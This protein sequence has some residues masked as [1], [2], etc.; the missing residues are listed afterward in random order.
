MKKKLALTGYIIGVTLLCLYVL[1]PKEAVTTYLNYR[2]SALS[3]DFQWTLSG[4]KPA[5]PPGIFMDSLSV[6][7]K[8]T[9]LIQVDKVKLTLSPLSLFTSKKKFEVMGNLCDGV[10]KVEA[11][12]SSLASPFIASANAVLEGVQLAKLPALSGVK[13]WRFSGTLKG[14]AEYAAGGQGSAEIRIAD[15]EIRFTPPLYG[16]GQVSF[17]S[18]DADLGLSGQQAVLKK[19]T[20]EGRDVSGRAEGRMTL[21]KP[22]SASPIQLTGDINPHPGMMKQLGNQF[23][24]EL[25]SNMK[26]KTGGI[27]FRIS[28]T[29]E[30]PNFSFH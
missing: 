29:V 19:L 20:V 3:P 21:G 23:P 25:V 26:T 27:P 28:G 11:V 8:E 1:F 9:K 7:H 12:S 18:V 13:E 4:V 24:L 15:S 22:L 2:I 17:K 6:S 30:R 5:F 16:V 14:K 10:V